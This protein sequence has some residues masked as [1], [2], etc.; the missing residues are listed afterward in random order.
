MQEAQ[1]YSFQKNKIKETATTWIISSILYNVGTSIFSLLT[2][3]IRQSFCEAGIM[4]DLLTL[5]WQ[6]LEINFQESICR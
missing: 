4:K 3:N 1:G 6:S 2:Q 5:F